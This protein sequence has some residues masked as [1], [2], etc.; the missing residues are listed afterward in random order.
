MIEA[1]Y[2]MLA[3]QMAVVLRNNAA[4]VGSAAGRQELESIAMRL[5]ALEH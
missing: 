1:I 4:T 2:Q 3:Q 5:L